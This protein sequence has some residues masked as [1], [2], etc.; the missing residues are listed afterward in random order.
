EPDPTP[1]A[2]QGSSTP[3]AS[4]NGWIVTIATN[5]ATP[6]DGFLNKATAS[7]EYTTTTSMGV[8]HKSLP[9][10]TKIELY[11]PRTGLYCIATVN[12]RGPYGAKGMANPDSFDFQM[13]VTEALGNNTGWYEVHYRIL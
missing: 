13:A 7:G 3:S 8:A 9:L 10:G 11:S 6:G 1:A 4:N 2:S 5:Y 12:D